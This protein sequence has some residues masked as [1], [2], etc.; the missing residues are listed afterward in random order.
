MDMYNVNTP[1]QQL[2]LHKVYYNAELPVLN[3][4]YI[5]KQANA[6]GEPFTKGPRKSSGGQV[7]NETLLPPIISLARTIIITGI[8][9][10]F[11]NLPTHPAHVQSTT[12][13]AGV[14]DSCDCC[15][16]AFRERAIRSP[17]LP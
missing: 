11:V 6:N 3:C 10:V 16:A 9:I 14:D 2:A 15:G 7:R 17:S 13:A 1:T 5:L 12:G 4:P 8:T